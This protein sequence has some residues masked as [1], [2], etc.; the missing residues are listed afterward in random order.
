MDGG[1]ERRMTQVTPQ[2]IKDLRERTGVGFAKCK[3]ALDQAKGDMEEA[4]SIL[5]KAGMASSVKKQGREAKE[6]MCVFKEND[7]YIALAEVNAE[8][9]FVAKNDKFQE[10]ANNIAEEILATHPKSLEEFL[11]QK[12]SKDPSITIDEYRSL[13]IQ[14]IGENILVSRILV[15]PKA[16]NHSYGIYSHMNGK[17]LSCVELSATEENT[18]AREL[19]MHVAASSP[20]YVSSKEVP[21]D[22]IERE[23]E[24]AKGQLQGKPDHMMDKM[25]QGKLNAYFGIACLT[26]QKFF[27]DTSKT[28][29]QYVNEQAQQK[30]APIDIVNFVRWM[31][32]QAL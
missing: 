23:K 29:I 11:K 16:K 25:V 26:D 7:N 9:D 27:K 17:I 2:M 32:G 18:L 30:G 28:V 3:E 14:M 21:N 19:A 6:G 22:V 8:T 5:R 10:F 31:T 4:I 24:V 13:I 20:E 15:L 12:Y 1:K